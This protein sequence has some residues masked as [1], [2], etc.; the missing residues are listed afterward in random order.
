MKFYKCITLLLAKLVGK[1][2]RIKSHNHS[3]FQNRGNLFDQY[4]NPV[5][6]HL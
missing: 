3:I 4:G 2:K 1:H 6:K 5:Y